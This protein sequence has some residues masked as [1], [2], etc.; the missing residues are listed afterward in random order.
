MREGFKRN[1][2]IDCNFVSPFSINHRRT[3]RRQTTTCT[4]LQ[5]LK[6]RLTRFPAGKKSWATWSFIAFRFTASYST[7]GPWQSFSQ[8]QARASFPKT[9]DPINLRTLYEKFCWKR[10]TTTKMYGILPSKYR[11][12]KFRKNFV[13]HKTVPQYRT[14]DPHF[15]LWILTF[16]RLNL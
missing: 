8:N 3:K 14:R 10:G 5:A 15:Y 13:F 7:W 4:P 1:E 12:R 6:T 2:A 9:N 11:V 16:T